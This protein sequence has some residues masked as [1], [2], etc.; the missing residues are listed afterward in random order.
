MRTVKSRSAFASLLLAIITLAGFSA[1][2]FADGVMRDGIGAV[3]TSR[4]GTNLGFADTGTMILDNPG[5]MVHVD[6]CGLAELGADLLIT[7]LDYSDP[8]NPGGV[9]S[10]NNPFPMG[11]LAVV[12]RL[13]DR[14]IA[15]GLGA[16]SQAGFAATYRMNGPV[17]FPGEQTYKSVGAMMRILPGVSVAL[18]DRLS[19]GATLGVAVSHTELEGPY[20]TQA[21]TPFIG[22]PT[23]LDL[24][25]T[26]AGLS[27]SIGMQYILSPQTTIGF[28]YQGETHIDAEGSARLTHPVLGSSAYDLELETQWPSTLGVGL[29]HQL[30]PCTTIGIDLLWVQW[31]GAKDSYDM[32]LTNPT[33]PLFRAILGPEVPERFPLDWSN[34]ISIRT[35]IQRQ[36]GNGRVVRAGYVYHPNPIPNATLTPFIQT[37]PEHAVSVGHGWSIGSYSF[38]VGY[39]YM[40]G[41]DREL[42]Q[43]GFVG[44]DFYNSKSS[45]A[46]HWLLTS[47]IRRF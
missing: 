4:G 33:N 47:I 37:T 15:V 3:S 29:A 46:A 12:R 8:D 19:V 7:D 28:L 21:Q 30:N 39:Q 16:F 38:D 24:Q 35:G 13:A 36:L 9:S 45:A 26:G 31:A 25:A 5:A 1:A 44:G 42:G 32:S 18:T 10:S 6:G 20:F 17:P 41:T 2:A 14:D 23:L 40:F 27:W 22:T 43:S 34:T 11:Q